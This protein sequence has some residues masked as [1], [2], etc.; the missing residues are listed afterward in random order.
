MYI[1]SATVAQEPG[2]VTFGDY[3]LYRAAPQQ[4]GPWSDSL[5][6]ACYRSPPRNNKLRTMTSLPFI[7]PAGSSAKDLVMTNETRFCGTAEAEAAH[8]GRKTEHR[9][10]GDHIVKAC[11]GMVVQEKNNR[12]ERTL[13]MVNAG[14]RMVVQQKHRIK[15]ERRPRLR[16]VR[17]CGSAGVVRV[18]Q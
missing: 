7:S 9:D 3:I 11:T 6:V 5:D 8:G 10:N 2:V 12:T 14:T 1:R 17:A 13:L 15:R 4:S 18:T 16:P